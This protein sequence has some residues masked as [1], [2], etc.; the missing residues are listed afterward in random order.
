MRQ[1]KHQV[2]DVLVN[3]ANILE[4]ADPNGLDFLCTSDPEITQHSRATK[5]LVRFI[6]NNFDKGTPAPCLINKVLQTLVD[7]VIDRLPDGIGEEQRLR[8]HIESR[9][10]RPISIYIL[11][12]GAWDCSPLSKDGTV[13]ADRPIKQLITELER[14]NLRKGQVAFHFIHF[15]DSLIDIERLVRLDDSESSMVQAPT[16]SKH[17]GRSV[18]PQVASSDDAVTTYP[19][20]RSHQIS[21][22]VRFVNEFSEELAGAFPNSLVTAELSQLTSTLP[23]LL[24]AFVA[25]LGLCDSSP[26][27]KLLMYLVKRYRQ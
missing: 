4:A 9:E 11:T 26:I 25:K 12:N 8:T 5:D 7:K 27:S 1:F 16:L 24:E 21:G 22:L 17:P 18:K 10:T 14:R 13:G 6:R 2:L 19:G 15:G 3:L 23:P 20:A